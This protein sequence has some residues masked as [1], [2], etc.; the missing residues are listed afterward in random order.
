MPIVTRKNKNETVLE[1]QGC[2]GASEA[3]R[4]HDLLLGSERHGVVTID[5]RDVRGIDDSVLARLAHDFARRPTRVLGLS[6]HQRRVL[7][8]F[9]PD[10][11]ARAPHCGASDPGAERALV[12]RDD[13]PRVLVVGHD[14]DFRAMLSELL[15]AEGY[16]VREAANLGAAI[17]HVT[18]RRPA[19]V[20]LDLMMSSA[21]PILRW[22]RHH[23]R[24]AG[25]PVVVISQAAPPPDGASA[26][27]REPIE[28][29]ALAAILKSVRANELDASAP[30]PE[31]KRVA[32]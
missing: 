32:G 27:V 10:C 12:L 19:V 14:S 7:R 28:R 29:G 24:A 13:L 21:P 16:E 3:E 20:L 9:A 22:L 18:D 11:D 8:Y 15:S 25:I 26:V 23:P 5:F 6:E 30:V 2:F 17:R 4:L 1:V 31:P